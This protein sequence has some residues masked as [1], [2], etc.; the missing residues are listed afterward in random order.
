MEKT[1][2]TPTYLRKSNYGTHTPPEWQ[3]PWRIIEDEDI[4]RYFALQFLNEVLAMIY[5]NTRN[6]DIPI[7]G[8][9]QGIQAEREEIY[10]RLQM[11]S[12][13]LSQLST[14]EE[15]SIFMDYKYMRQAAEQKMGEALGAT[16]QD[17]AITAGWRKLFSLFDKN[18]LPDEALFLAQAIVDT[19]GWRTETR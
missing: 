16:D 10:N 4:A 3:P 17:A 6:F 7:A 2:Y 15:S 14:G 18:M 11:K 13:Y 5:Q 12:M 8:N 19:W 1:S 9:V